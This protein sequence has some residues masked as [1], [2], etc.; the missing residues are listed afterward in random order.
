MDNKLCIK[1]I[2]SAIQVALFNKEE[3]KRVASNA[4]KTKYG[5]YI[6]ITAAVLTFLGKQIFRS[7]FVLSIGAGIGI[8]VMQVIMIVIGIYIMSIVANKLFDGTANNEAFFR[9]SSYAI[10]I[11]WLTLIPVLDI[12]AWLWGLILFIIILR[13]VQK[14]SVG[15]VVGTLIVG[16]IIMAMVSMILTPIFATFGIMNTGFSFGRHNNKTKAVNVLNK[17]INDTN[18]EMKS[19]DGEGGVTMKD[20]KMTITGSDGETMEINVSK[21]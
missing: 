20:G 3:M 17:K 8:A 1:E 2:K 18:F 13:T 6:I 10:I 7:W 19:P 14:L 21:K 12:I 4:D 15:G 5:Y 16:V 11:Q 9:V